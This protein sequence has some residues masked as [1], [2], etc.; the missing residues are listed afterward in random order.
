MYSCQHLACNFVC[1]VLSFIGS[2]DEEC[3]KMSL[4]IV[5][6]I[7]YLRNSRY[8]TEELSRKEV[9]YFQWQY[10]FKFCSISDL[11]K[12]VVDLEKSEEE[13]GKQL[14]FLSDL[15]IPHIK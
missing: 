10:V 15:Y 1:D 5:F 8:L 11:Y 3:R 14:N 4:F 2:A 9:L 6:F 13:Y 12:C 7:I